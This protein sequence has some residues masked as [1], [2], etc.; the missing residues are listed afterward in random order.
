VVRRL[1]ERGLGHLTQLTLGRGSLRRE[2]FAMSRLDR[3]LAQ[4]SGPQFAEH[5]RTDDL[6]VAQVA[7]RIA[8]DAGLTLAKNT[9]GPVLAR[10]RRGLIG[11][12]HIRFG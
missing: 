4:L 11:V 6:T 12:R 8:A 2:T 1:R 10:F 3:C 7:D 9:D 5:I